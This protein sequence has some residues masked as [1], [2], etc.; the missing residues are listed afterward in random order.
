LF[1]H[2]PVDD[3]SGTTVADS[4]GNGRNGTITQSSNPQWHFAPG[5]LDGSGAADGNPITL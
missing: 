4:S 5:L 3:G 1:L 2:L